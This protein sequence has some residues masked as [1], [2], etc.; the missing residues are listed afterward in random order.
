VR[1]A[2]PR[3]AFVFTCA[4]NDSPAHRPALA[5]LKH[6]L[7][8]FDAE[9][10]VAPLRYRN[11]TSDRE[12]GAEY[13]WDPVLAPYLNDGRLQVCKGLQF[14]GDIKTQ[15]TAVRPLSGLDTIT[16]A[17]CGLVPHPKVALDTIATRGGDLPKIMWSTGA[18]TKPVYSDTKAGKKGEFH[19]VM[20][21]IVVH[22]EPS[23]RFHM[24][25][26]GF[27]ADGSFID[28][29]LKFTKDGVEKAPR[30]LGMRLGDVHGVRADPKAIA[31]TQRMI[32]MLQPQ[33]VILDD[34]LD[35]NSGSHHNGFFQ[36]FLNR[37]KQRDDVAT[38][39]RETCKLIDSFH[40]PD[41]KL[42]IVSSNHH[43]HLLKW[44]AD[45]RN[46]DD[47]Q[48][49]V[50]YHRLKAEVLAESLERDRVVNPFEI[51]S[52]S[53]LKH[54]VK[55]I[56]DR[57]SYVVGG[58]ENCYH[59]HVGPGGSRGSAKAYAKIGLRVNLGHSHTPCIVDGCYQGGTLSLLDMGYN[60]GPSGWIHCNIVTYA[61]RQRT[62]VFI[63]DGD[64]GE[65]K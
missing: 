4:V 5:A 41:Q 1:Q 31:A 20:G 43:D 18:I 44:L 13:R 10:V 21:A 17:M 45:S 22:V 16:G 9:L 37:H 28:L 60:V 55:W 26:I 64:F 14:L 38:E 48:N 30:A 50:L 7:D 3:S 40:R 35:F 11:P 61:S 15:P 62:M 59:G 8:Y 36:K 29:D 57:G 53:L 2:A 51:A 32:D 25:R 12:K 47:V 6:Y 63:I 49:A 24:R 58:I 23:G 33:H 42:A 46:A 52:R 34:V 56:G 19:H 54:P 39:L 65:R 27:A